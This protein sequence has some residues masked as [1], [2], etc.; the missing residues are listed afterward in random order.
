M[1]KLSCSSDGPWASNKLGLFKGERES[2]CVCVRMCDGADL[3]LTGLGPL[4]AVA[5]VKSAVK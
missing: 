1:L 4:A 3:C 5:Y 2:V